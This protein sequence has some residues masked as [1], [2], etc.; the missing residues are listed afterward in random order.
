MSCHLSEV[1]A[2][3]QI[4]IKRFLESVYGLRVEAVRTVNYEGK[5]KRRKQGVFRESDY[6]KVGSYYLLVH[7]AA[8][9][10]QSIGMAIT[11]LASPAGVTSAVKLLCRQACIEV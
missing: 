11:G 6:K 2:R 7:A 1:P 10:L 5:R 9:K 8:R 3:L 4:E